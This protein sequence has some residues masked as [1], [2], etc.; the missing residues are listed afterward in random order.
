VEKKGKDLPL[1]HNLYFASL[2]E[3]CCVQCL[4]IGPFNSVKSTYTKIEEYMKENGLTQNGIWNE[5]YLSDKR[6]TAPEKLRTIIR[7]PVV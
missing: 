2:N 3:G 5:I 7:C 6:K 4:H 1:L